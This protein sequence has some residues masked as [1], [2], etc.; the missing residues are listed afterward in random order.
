MADKIFHHALVVPVH[1]PT[2]LPHLPVPPPPLL[3]RRSYGRHAAHLSLA[4][5]RLYDQREA[6]NSLR[7]LVGASAGEFI[8]EFDLHKQGCGHICGLAACTILADSLMALRPSGGEATGRSTGTGSGIA[9]AGTNG[10][11]SARSISS[12]SIGSIG[13]GS[14]GNNASTPGSVSKRQRSSSSPDLKR[15]SFMQPVPTASEA[16]AAAAAAVAA[17][18]AVAVEG[19]NTPPQQSQLPRAATPT[20]A[21]G[22]AAARRGPGGGSDHSPSHTLGWFGSHKVPTEQTHTV[23]EAP[24]V[25]DACQEPWSTQT[26]EGSNGVGGADGDFGGRSYARSNKRNQPFTN[27]LPE[28]PYRKS[29]VSGIGYLEV[30]DGGTAEAETHGASMASFVDT[31][32][33]SSSGAPPRVS[34]EISSSEV[35]YTN[36]SDARRRGRDAAGTSA[37]VGPGSDPAATPWRP[38]A[39]L[40]LPAVSAA[41]SLKAGA[42]GHQGADSFRQKS[43]AAGAVRSAGRMM[44]RIDPN[45]SA[46]HPKEYVSP[47]AGG[48]ASLEASPSLSRQQQRNRGHH[49]RH[50][51]VDPAEWHSPS[52][53]GSEDGFGESVARGGG[54]AEGGG[55]GEGEGAKSARPD[56]M[57]HARRPSFR[58]GSDFDFVWEL[59]MLLEQDELSGELA[60]ATGVTSQIRMI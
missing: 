33:P 18:V 51:Q 24:T 29:P 6:Y 8:P 26:W 59:G 12:P 53:S 28:L 47:V 38:T 43:V 42:D 19:A 39:P 1:S 48:G 50:R 55:G 22:V 15:R 7:S 21:G 34:R 27:P 10:A 35:G 60:G 45:V 41:I 37:S 17:A 11:L 52:G 54:G 5:F 44:A 23:S 16:M 46:Q 20:S 30:G 40:T 3:P 31:F 13:S 49:R 25:T 2:S 4:V 9:D 56:L 32:P 57:T 36:R 58:P 14:G